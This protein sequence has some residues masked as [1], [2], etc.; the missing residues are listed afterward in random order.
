MDTEGSREAELVSAEEYGQELWRFAA[1]FWRGEWTDAEKDAT[2]Q[3][4]MKFLD[5]LDQAFKSG[6]LDEKVKADF[7]RRFYDNQQTNVVDKFYG[8]GGGQELAKKAADVLGVPF[9]E[10]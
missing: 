3:E 8:Y 2:R 9:Q 5:S 1:A 10:N 6:Q 7:V 4:A